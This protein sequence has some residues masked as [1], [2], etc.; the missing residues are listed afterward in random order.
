MK[1]KVCN[2]EGC[3]KVEV[4]NPADGDA[5]VSCSTVEEGQEVTLIATECHE[6]SQVEVGEVTATE[7]EEV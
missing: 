2:D 5:V 4:I 7:Q 1:I 6:P 3:A